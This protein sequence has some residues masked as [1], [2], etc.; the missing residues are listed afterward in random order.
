MTS[1]FTDSTKN[2]LLSQD[3]SD[4]N[5]LQITAAGSQQSLPVD[6]NMS[7]P[8]LVFN[9]ALMRTIGV[10]LERSYNIVMTLQGTLSLGARLRTMRHRRET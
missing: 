8:L 6:L 4:V 1:Q 5:N 3:S 2:V 7:S 10:A 9:S